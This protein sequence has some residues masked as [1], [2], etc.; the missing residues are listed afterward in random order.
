MV[1]IYVKLITNGRRTFEQ[2]PENLKTAVK[3]QLDLLELETNVGG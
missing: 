1:E 2:V 3:N